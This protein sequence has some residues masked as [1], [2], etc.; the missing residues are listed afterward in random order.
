[1]RHIFFILLFIINPFFSFSQNDCGGG[2][3]EGEYG[4]PEGADSTGMPQGEEFEIPI[5]VSMDPNDIIG[6]VGYDSL[7]WVAQTSILNYM[8]R[9]E[10]DPDFATAPAQKVII[11]LP[12]HENLI[13]GT[14]Q[15]KDYGF[16]AFNY[17]VN[18][19]TQHIATLTD[20]YDS[21]NVHVLVVAGIDPINNELFWEFSSID[22]S[23]GLPPTD[24]LTG[25]L[26][27]NDSTHIGE[28]YVTF[29]IT[30]KNTTVTGDSILAKASIVFDINAPIETNTWV[31]VIDAFPPSSTLNAL[32]D[33]T[34]SNQVTLTWS[35]QDDNG[36]VG[37]DFYDLYVSKDGGNFVLYQSDISTSYYTF[38]G[39][40]GAVYAFYTLATDYV[41]NQELPK[42]EGED[43]IRLGIR[44]S[45]MV[46]YP[47]ENS[48][49]C[50]NDTIQIEWITTDTFLINI[51]ISADSGQTFIPIASNISSISSPYNWAIPSTSSSGNDYMIQLSDTAIG[52]FQTNSSAFSIGQSDTTYLYTTSCNP[53]DTGTTTQ[54]Y[55]NQL[56]C[57]SL[58]IINT[59]FALADTTYLTA[60]TCDV[61]QV[62]Q[63]DI[64]LVGLDGC[65]SLVI[66]DVVLSNQAMLT[67]TDSIVPVNDT[68]QLLA[69]GGISYQWFPSVGLSND[70]IANPIA[71]IDSTITYT[72]SITTLDSCIFTDSVTYAVNVAPVNDDCA[73]AIELTIPYNGTL[74]EFTNLDATPSN[75]LSIPSTPSWLPQG[76]Q[77]QKDVWFTFVTPNTPIDVSI[78][79]NGC[80]P[81]PFHPK[82]ALYKGNCSF[83][84]LNQ[85]I[86]Q[87]AASTYSPT[88]TASIIQ[89]GLDPSTRYFL[90]VDNG[91]DPTPISGGDFTLTISDCITNW[92]FDVATTCDPSLVN[93]A[94][95]DT[96]QNIGGCDSLIYT[97]YIDGTSPIT[98]LSASTCD[99]NQVG[100]DT[101]SSVNQYGC[102]SIII[103]TTTLLQSDTTYLTA[104][105]CNPVDTGTFIQNL[106]N[107]NNCDSLVVITTTLLPTDTT[108]ITLT[109]CN[110]SQIGI[111]SVTITNQYGC[112]S[113]I[114]TNI[115]LLPSDTTILFMTSCNPLDTG[116]TTQVLPNVYNCD[117]IVITTTTLLQSDTT[118]LTATSCDLSQIGVNVNTLINQSGCDS[119]VI[120]T[121]LLLPS[122]TTYLTVSTC[123]VSQVGIMTDTFSN[124]FGCDSLV[125]TNTTLFSTIN[126]TVSND[127]TVCEN[128]QVQLL[129]TGGTSYNW[130]PA[131]GLNNPNVANPVLSATTTTTYF[132]TITDI[133]GC[134]TTDSVVIIVNPAPIITGQTTF[135]DCEGSVFQMNISGGLNYLW[136]PNAFLN[137]PNI[138]NPII[139]PPIDSIYYYS[140]QVTDSLGCQKIGQVTINITPNPTINI[141]ND[142]LICYETNTQISASGGLNYSWSPANSL[143]DSTLASPIAS[144]EVTTTY[145]V[146]VTDANGCSSFG[147]T[148]VEVADTMPQP[149]LSL[150]GNLISA[151][152]LGVGYTWFYSDTFFTT[153]NGFMIVPSGIGLP[154]IFGDST[155]YYQVWVEDSLGCV[156]ESETFFFNIPPSNNEHQLTDNELHPFSNVQISPNP[157]YNFVRIKFGDDLK[158]DVKVYLYNNLGQ[159]A[160]ETIIYSNRQEEIIDISN[161]PVGNYHIFLVDGNVNIS[162]QLIKAK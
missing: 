74:C 50:L 101:V 41:G 7:Q 80:F 96:L 121:T 33:E 152:P 82:M 94:Y 26:P 100:I 158:S 149:S 142:T 105:S 72:V 19:G 107:I 159:L 31:N 48:Q 68:I 143:N 66:I 52:G 45:L 81:Q 91:I 17:T 137:N 113:T 36:G 14:I 56:G 30:P 89:Y 126:T 150:N 144:P 151:F 67:N 12:I 35:G 161:L 22:P 57:D 60:T 42:F 153:P 103:T 116:V 147:T 141:S 115:S 77:V 122:D 78:V 8:I 127:T 40:S 46:I 139:T 4:I 59:T 16:G 44:D 148:T 25:F 87:P 65:D 28:G 10:N 95:V 6:E 131:I 125:I 38:V 23:T 135:T 162:Y 85:G 145:S 160:K 86:G 51:A 104:T 114:I 134:I 83:M 146:V 99:V 156:Y 111:N 21:L 37:I 27:V 155:G 84:V 108:Y 130:F 76:N 53:S 43:S 71:V 157:A 24:A 110:P 9:F 119:L 18:A 154:S 11:R 49:L 69:T 93:T 75:V 128:Q 79:I 54:T 133:N 13:G 138:P 88:N 1:M 129:A 97:T 32:P 118:Y 112:D 140:V 123:D 2:D 120:T 109:T 70:T 58:V 136:T 117:S 132:V 106:I 102:D 29:T 92:G 64:L 62:G 20:T 90:R 63:I 61:N 3:D 47:N 5:V 15:I 124:Q 73:D 39:D 98:Y 34:D 55:P